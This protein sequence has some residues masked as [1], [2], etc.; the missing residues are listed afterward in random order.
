MKNARF[1]PWLPA[2]NRGQSTSAGTLLRTICV[3]GRGRATLREPLDR[4]EA[5]HG[6]ALTEAPAAHG[7]RYAPVAH[8]QR[9]APVAHWAALRSCGPQAMATPGCAGT[10]TP[11]AAAVWLP[12]QTHNGCH[13]Y[14]SASTFVIAT[15]HATKPVSGSAPLKHRPH[16]PLNPALGSQVTAERCSRAVMKSTDGGCHSFRV[17]L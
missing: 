8:R 17:Q 1:G 9:Y 15:C 14:S 3:A 6:E 2:G 4:R 10:P 12:G 11:G 16:L 7:Q 13:L 5:A